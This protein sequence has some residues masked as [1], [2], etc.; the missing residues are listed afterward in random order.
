M[1][2]FNDEL[3]AAR[4]AVAA[5]GLAPEQFGFTREDIA[6]D[7]EEAADGMFTLRYVVTVT[8][9]SESRRYTGG[10]GLNWI[11]AFEEDLR[12]GLF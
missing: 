9:K 3:A 4:K 1:D 12:A 7:P 8:R 5:Q 2:Q 6:P 11:R 10:I